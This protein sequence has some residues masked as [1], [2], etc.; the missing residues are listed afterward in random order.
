MNIDFHCHY[1]PANFPELVCD[2]AH[3]YSP[4]V[5]DGP[6]GSKLITISGHYFAPHTVELYDL[7]EEMLAMER[8]DID[9]QVL[10]V[11]PYALFYWA[12]PEVASAAA[13]TLNDALS[14]AVREE[15]EHFVV[16]A[17]APLPAPAAAAAEV[18]RAVSQLGMRGMA[19]GASVYGGP[20]SSPDLRPF[21]QRVQ[22][23]GV[24]VFLHP[25]NTP[26]TDLMP[27][28]YLWNLIGYP[29]ETAL[30]AAH[31]MFG[32]VLES[33]PSLN[34]CL[35]HGCGTLPVLL[36]RMRH[37]ARVRPEL[38]G[39]TANSPMDL[40][41]RRYYDSLTHSMR[42]LHF[43]VDMVGCDR[44]ILGSGFP[45]DMRDR[46]PIVAI[47]SLTRP[48]LQEIDAILRRHAAAL[49]GI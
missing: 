2:L 36:G 45:F 12:D 16:L 27:D 40:A 20:L 31:L 10:S 15:P 9:M 25:T 41:K 44:I 6:R 5:S 26:M 1:L 49:R 21:F 48:N 32:G 37:A 38:R 33:F 30:A 28:F 22:E 4:Q 39:T 11:P 13:R 7:D 42:A 34:I 3:M 23:L 46:D 43:L 29:T 19:I 24:P 18:G 47:H 17:T 14:Q 8:T 35:A